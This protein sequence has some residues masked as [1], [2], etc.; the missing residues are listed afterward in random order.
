VVCGDISLLERAPEHLTFDKI[1]CSQVLGHVPCGEAARIVEGFAGRLRP[2][3]S[4]AISIP[5]IGYADSDSSSGTTDRGDFTH[6]VNLDCSHQSD[7]YRRPVPEDV[8]ERYA[9]SPEPNL[10]PVRSFYTPG[11]F[12][13]K[14][15]E[16]PCTIDTFPSTLHPIVEHHFEISSVVLYSIHDRLRR[17]NGVDCVIGDLLITL[18]KRRA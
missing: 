9:R 16:L 4:C 3:G 6:L 13:V 15:T 2:G 1:L 14:S 7:D 18:K 5:V 10:L 11:I 8:F 17:E 12:S